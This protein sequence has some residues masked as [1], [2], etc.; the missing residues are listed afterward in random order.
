MCKP[1]KFRVF[2]CPQTSECFNINIGRMSSDVKMKLQRMTEIINY[3]GNTETT[4]FPKG[5]K[6]MQEISNLK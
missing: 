1:E 5:I 6:R 4:F 2:Y 3:V